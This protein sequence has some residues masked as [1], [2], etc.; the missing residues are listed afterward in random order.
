[1]PSL[2]CLPSLPTL[3]PQPPQPTLPPQPPLPTQ[4]PQPT[5]PT[6]PPQPT[7]ALPC[8]PAPQP[9][10]AY[11]AYP[12]FP[13]S[14]AYP[15]SPASPAS[16]AY[17]AYPAFPAS[18]AYPTST[19][20]GVLLTAPTC[21]HQPAS[22]N[23][24]APTCQHQPA[25]QPASTNLPAPTCQHQPASTNLPAPA[26]Q[27]QPASTNL[28]APTCQHHPASRRV[29][30]AE[31]ERLWS[32]REHQRVTQMC[33]EAEQRV[34]TLQKS[35]KRVIVKSKPYFELKAQFNHILEEH[36]GKVVQLEERVAKVKTRYSVALRNLEQISEQIHAQRGRVRATR[37]R[38]VACGGRSSPVGAE[39]EVRVQVGGACG[40][41]GG[42]GGG[43]GVGLEE[44]DWADGEKTRQWVERH[45]EQ[46][47]GH[48]ERGEA[49]S[50]SMSVV[51]L[52]TI[53]SDLEKCDSVEHLGDLSDVSSLMGEDW[54]RER[55]RSLIAENRDRNPRAEER[56][57][58]EVREVMEV[59]ELV[60]PTPRQ[61][62][63]E[64]VRGAIGRERQESFVKQH[65]RSV[66][67]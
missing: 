54:E 4:P 34:Q 67:L 60:I 45:R 55:D 47:W 39:A 13:A 50:D 41:G 35:L 26:C 5:L 1:L 62:R 3:P 10:P 27:H 53:A 40:G 61:D 51:S 15:A 52:Q 63:L 14:P 36:K 66:S 16:P 58:G 11:P 49:G 24:P 48:R 21:Q 37:A 64:E 25:S 42:G 59:R 33:Q 43:G 57:V 19:E 56:V 2:P 65:H 31:E 18:P 44:N 23:L 6:Q 12:A 17:P 8:L 30:E 7:P 32:E 20:P 29:N 28:P 38:P 46:G 22:T 9:P